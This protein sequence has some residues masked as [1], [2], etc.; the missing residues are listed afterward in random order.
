MAIL[1]LMLFIRKYFEKKYDHSES[2]RTINTNSIIDRVYLILLDCV[3]YR[4]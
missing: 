4:L 3:E 2:S 1:I